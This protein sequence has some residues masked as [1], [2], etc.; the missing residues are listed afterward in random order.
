MELLTVDLPTRSRHK[1]VLYRSL[2]GN[3]TW[4]E[5]ESV[6]STFS[7][8]VYQRAMGLTKEFYRAPLFMDNRAPG[9]VREKVTEVEKEETVHVMEKFFTG[10]SGQLGGTFYT[11]NTKHEIFDLYTQ[12]YQEVKQA[13]HLRGRELSDN[14]RSRNFLLYNMLTRISIRRVTKPHNCPICSTLGDK[15]A[16]L[17]KELAQT[18]DE[19]EREDIQGELLILQ[20]RNAR[21]EAHVAKKIYQRQHV[22]HVRDNLAERDVMVWMDFCSWH[23]EH[24]KWENLVCVVQFKEKNLLE[25]LYIDIPCC[26]LETASHNH[27]FY[28]HAWDVLFRDSGLFISNGVRRWDKI[29]RVSDNGTPFMNR[30]SCII[31]SYMQHKYNITMTVIPLCQYHAWSLCDSHGGVIKL[32]MKRAEIRDEV[33]STTEMMKAMLEGEI[34]RTFVYAQ[35]R[36]PVGI[37]DREL[38]ARFG[39]FAKVGPVPGL[40]DVG[41]I[42][43]PKFRHVLTRRRPGHPDSVELRFIIPDNVQAPTWHYFNQLTSEIDNNCKQCSMLHMRPIPKHICMLVPRH[44]SRI[45]KKQRQRFRD[46]AIELTSGE[47]DVV[48]ESDVEADMPTRGGPVLQSAREPGAAGNDKDEVTVVQETVAPVFPVPRAPPPRGRNSKPVRP[49]TSPARPAM[50]YLHSWPL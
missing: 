7:R 12:A 50:S 27:Y 37:I 36:I 33:P 40:G 28:F 38:Y 34:D 29:I 22:Q 21:V 18:D 41:H 4:Q 45:G 1:T 20:R 15:I 9:E 31:D 11:V 23:S 44:Q 42:S 49:A 24:V 32:K 43:Y 5:I 8:S 16:N 2:L 30:F 47:D 35:D 48:E 25:T 26:D 6:S 14:P 19:L 10:K 46:N 39:G 13:C 3:L 17:R